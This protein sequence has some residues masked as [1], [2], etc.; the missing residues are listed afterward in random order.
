[1]GGYGSGRQGGKA[2]VEGCRS[3]KL[4]VNRVTRAVRSALRDLPE[5][6]G[7]TAGPSVWSWTAPGETVLCAR[8][9]VT[10]RLD[11]WRGEARLQFDV[12]HWSRKTGPQDQVVQM[13]TTPCRYGGRRWW[14]LCPV[15]WRR[16]ATLYLPNGGTRFLSRGPGAYRLAY[17]SQ[18]SGPL[19]RSHGRLARVHRK[20]GGEYDGLY[21][22][23][24]SR[25]KWMR[26]RTYD[27]LVTE[28]EAQTGQHE[29]MW[30]EGAE[31]LI[32]RSRV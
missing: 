25:P 7:L 32:S 26:H 20:L 29:D 17:A 8:V 10:L 4:N 6:R 23:L 13:E 18:N 22:P 1:M 19:E 3:L 30:L 16:C 24:P 9:L 21:S 14:W 5:G 31:R 11:H 28:W 15:T 27:R 12:D 2:T